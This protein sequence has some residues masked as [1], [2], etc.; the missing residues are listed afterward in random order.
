MPV[1]SYKDLDAWKLAMDFVV[2]VYQLTRRFP[3]EETYGLTS[4]L[5][6]AVVA[7]PSNVSEGHRQGGR[8]FLRHVV[9][10]LGSLAEAETQLEIAYRMNYV[11][12]DDIQPATALGRDVRRLLFGLRRTLRRKHVEGTNSPSGF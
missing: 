1:Q 4:Q 10:A 6:R 8:V 9:I 7:I 11:S 5:R 3:R 2:A 12:A